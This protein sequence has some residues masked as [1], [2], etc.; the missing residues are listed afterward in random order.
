MDMLLTL[1]DL[2]EMAKDSGNEKKAV[3]TAVA[4]GS[5]TITVSDGTHT[6]TIAV[7]VNAAA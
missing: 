6:D 1:N 4:A 3:I 2:K 5:A 7:T